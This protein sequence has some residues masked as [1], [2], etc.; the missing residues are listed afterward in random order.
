M[1]FKN[2]LKENAK[3]VEEELD[4]ILT[5]FLKEVKTVSPK[6]SSLAQEFINFSQGGKRVRGVLCILGYQLAKG[7]GK[8]IIKI[9]AALEIL[10]SAILAHDDIIDKSSLRRGQP[11]LHQA[12]GGNQYGI[13]QALVLGD[14]GL[15]LQTRVITSSTFPNKTKI[16]AINH[17]SQTIISTGLGQLLDVKLHNSNI[18]KASQDDMQR[19]YLLKTALYTI[20]GPLILGAILAGSGSK[21]IKAVKNFGENLGIAYQ[22][23]DDILDKEATGQ[24]RKQLKEYTEL[25]EKIIPKL[26]S[27]AKIRLLLKDLCLY[28]LERTR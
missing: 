14:I 8:E 15:Y 6:L 21:L 10:H 7:S 22:I 18:S 26:S 23:K 28:L 25:A 5:K 12:L 13:S 2:Y 1:D 27:N 4:K 16:K 24:A 19:L 20:S 17:L 9:G 11:T 3:K